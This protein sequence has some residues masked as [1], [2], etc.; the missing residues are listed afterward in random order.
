VL[1][2]IDGM[3]LQVI[4]ILE[5]RGISYQLRLYALAIIHS[6]VYDSMKVGQTATPDLISV[7]GDFAAIDY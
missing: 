6:L 2:V 3:A 4:S 1:L 5:D 7:Y